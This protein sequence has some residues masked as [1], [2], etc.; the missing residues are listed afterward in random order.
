MDL[1][2]INISWSPKVF[3]HNLQKASENITLQ[4]FSLMISNGSSNETIVLTEP[5]YTFNFPEGSPPCDVYNFTVAATYVGA[6]Y[7]G[8]GCSEPSAVISITHP[9]LPDIEQLESSLEN[10]LI[11]SRNDDHLILRISFN[12]SFKN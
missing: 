9:F 6:L 11:L 4:T 1:Y 3:T 10:T 5:H 12:V 8:A 2:S 7:T